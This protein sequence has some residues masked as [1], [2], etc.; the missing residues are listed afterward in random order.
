MTVSVII[1]THNPR[2]N[3]LDRVLQ[4]LENQ[5]LSPTEWEL[6]IIDNASKEPVSARWNVSWH[7]N[8]RIVV[9]EELGL[10]PARLRGI[11]ES[12]GGLIIFVDDDNILGPDYLE[13]AIEV[14][15]ERPYMGAFSGS[16][17]G[18][19]EVSP[20]PWI[21]RYLLMLAVRETQCDTCSNLPGS[22]NK[23]TPYGAGMCVRRTVAE[24]Y[25]SKV[26]T[27][28]KRRALDRVGKGTGSAGD[29][30]LAYCALDLGFQIGTF[31][32][33]KMLHL[34]PK[35]RLSIDYIAR[36]SAGCYGSSV[37]LR[38][39][40]PS[41]APTPRKKRL[42][43]AV[44]LLAKVALAPLPHAKIAFAAYAGRR[45]AQAFI[46]RPNLDKSLLQH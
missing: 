24:D 11:S 14:A 29:L 22:W 2:K 21:Q 16:I 40:R 7:P 31:C 19:F 13:R 42:V 1:C 25:R 15:A 9:E 46:R 38:S 30:D 34:I 5:T 36:L 6:L 26:L 20:Q 32:R 12:R 18:E 28:P 43:M 37:V 17:K 44:H 4:A 41:T 23:S 33:L 3:Y 8:S 39:L 10:T 35:Q 45:K 27:D